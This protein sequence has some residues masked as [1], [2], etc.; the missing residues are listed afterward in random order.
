MSLVHSDHRNTR[1][2]ATKA[3]YCQKAWTA[4]FRRSEMVPMERKF[5]VL[6]TPRRTTLMTSTALLRLVCPQDLCR[7][8]VC[9]QGKPIWTRESVP[10]TRVI[11]GFSLDHKVEN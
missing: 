3:A 9:V 1:E 5:D 10:H 6:S 8:W 7:T 4:S 2:F 11:D